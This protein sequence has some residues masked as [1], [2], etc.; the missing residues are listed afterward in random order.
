MYGLRVVPVA[1]VYYTAEYMASI[2]TNSA[3]TA[4]VEI[5]NY[6]NSATRIIS[7]IVG[8]TPQPWLPV[9]VNIIPPNIERDIALVRTTKIKTYKFITLRTTQ[10]YIE[11]IKT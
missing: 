11:D 5:H 1:L 4:K 2:W 6:I 3:Y 10:Q 7:G 8:S 9:L